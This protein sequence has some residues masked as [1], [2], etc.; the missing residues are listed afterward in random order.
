MLL[1]STTL[2]EPHHLSDYKPSLLIR[3]L[4]E[5]E[6]ELEEDIVPRMYVEVKKE[7]PSMQ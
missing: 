1:M 4:E 5:E 6:E 3:N 7:N 2:K